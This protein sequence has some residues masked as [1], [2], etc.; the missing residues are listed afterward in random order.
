MFSRR[1]ILSVILTLTAVVSQ[2]VVSAE[3]GVPNIRVLGQLKQNIPPDS[4]EIELQVQFRSQDLPAA[5][6]EI[7][8]RQQKLLGYLDA[9]GLPKDS[10]RLRSLSTSTIYGE[11]GMSKEVA[12]YELSQE[13]LV[14]LKDISRFSTFQSGLLSLGVVTIQQI[15]ALSSQAELIK[16]QLLVKAL[17]VARKKAF[18]LASAE[19][20]QLGPVLD[21]TEGFGGV[22]G[23][24]D[25]IA[26]Q[27]I[28]ILA[29]VTV[30][31]EL[32]PQ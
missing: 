30:T 19:G 6:K 2:A 3:S 10:V 23:G 26:V 12:Y 1:I 22:S 25:N 7:E 31:Y 15:R 21:I 13:L 27:D 16:Q 24:G 32:R 20:M 4:L 18:A 14:T 11:K 8:V 5:I 9:F 17:G 29:E 28:E